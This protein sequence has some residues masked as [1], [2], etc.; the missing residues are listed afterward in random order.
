MIYRYAISAEIEIDAPNVVVAEKFL[1]QS[2]RILGT[3]VRIIGDGSSSTVRM[4][5]T[6]NNECGP[7][8]HVKSISAAKIQRLKP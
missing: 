3:P 7:W 1:R 2:R 4:P 5:S 8:V 6:P